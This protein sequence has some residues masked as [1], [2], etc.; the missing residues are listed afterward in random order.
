MEDKLVEYDGT[1]DELTK[2]LVADVESAAQELEI[3]L[4]EEYRKAIERCIEEFVA[5]VTEAEAEDDRAEAGMDKSMNSIC[6]RQCVPKL[7]ARLAV[8]FV[9]NKVIPSDIISD[10][11]T[12]TVCGK[13][14][15]I[16]ENKVA[17]E[18][19]CV[20]CAV[21]TFTKQRLS[22]HFTEADIKGMMRPA[23]EFKGKYEELYGEK[24]SQCLRDEEIHSALLILEDCNLIK[25]E[26]GGYKSRAWWR[27]LWGIP[28]DKPNG[29]V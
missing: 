19:Y 15:N 8:E 24:C 14:K 29:A 11:V 2:M 4:S 9:A 5:D 23:C 28:E 18:L 20:L 17:R 10:I 26:E 6:I 27:F 1:R 16:P 3:E 7:I 12:D 25:R 22:H 13:I 21:M